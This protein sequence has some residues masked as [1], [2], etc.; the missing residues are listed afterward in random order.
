MA[1]EDFNINTEDDNS[2]NNSEFVPSNIDSD[3]EVEKNQPFPSGD[4]EKDFDRMLDDFI[5]AQL[6]EINDEQQE[7]IESINNNK[8]LPSQVE[9]DDNLADLLYA[10]ERA[11]YDAYTKLL[12]A[13]Q[14]M[15]QTENIELPQF[16]FGAALIY[17][18]FRP[19]RSKL[20]ISDTLKCWEIMLQAQP[21]RLSGLKARASDEEI[22]EF[23]EKTTDENL[24]LALI[25]YVEILIELEN[26]E[27]SYNLRKAKFKKRKIEREIY[28]EHKRRTEKMKKFIK[29]ISE[30]NFPIDAERLVNNYFKNA[31]KDP[32]SARKMLENNPATYAPIEINKLKPRFFG[33]IKPKPEDGIK[34]N[35]EIGRF[36]KKL[37]A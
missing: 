34:I 7:I 12:D 8:P 20:L 28:E 26:C 17:Q 27:L 16:E 30:A 37:K 13:I 25:S 22:L 19:S 10:D 23:A 2:Y 11:L 3:F 31:R 9:Q 36:L 21:Q 15:A 1:T 5:S 18:R 6:S 33:L 24:Q 32:E 14:F 35:K 29:A 4:S